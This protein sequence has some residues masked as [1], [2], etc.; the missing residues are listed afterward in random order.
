MDKKTEEGY[1]SG[2]ISIIVAGVMFIGALNSTGEAQE[3]AL[4]FSVIFGALGVGS[5]LR[6]NTIGSILTRFFNNLT[7]K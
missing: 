6:P 3:G 2:I 7:S 1:I 4:L 5:I